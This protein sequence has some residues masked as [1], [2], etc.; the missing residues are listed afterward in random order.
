MAGGHVH[1]ST[2]IIIAAL[3]RVESRGKV[4]SANDALIH[5]VTK[6][7]PQRCQVRN[8]KEVVKHYCVSFIEFRNTLRTI[9][10]Y[11]VRHSTCSNKILQ[12]YAES[13]RFDR[14]ETIAISNQYMLLTYLKFYLVQR[15][16]SMSPLVSHLSKS[17][18][19]DMYVQM[20]LG[21]MQ[22]VNIVMMRLLIM[23][24]R[25]CE[26]GTFV[27]INRRNTMLP[28]LH[29][30]VHHIRVWSRRKCRKLH[31]YP[32]RN[33]R[34]LLLS[35]DSNT[36]HEEIRK[37][38]RKYLSNANKKALLHGLNLLSSAATDIVHRLVCTVQIAESLVVTPLCEPA[39]SR[40]S[41]IALYVCPMCREVKNTLAKYTS[42]KGVM[43]DYETSSILCSGKKCS[44]KDI[45]VVIHPIQ[46]SVSRTCIVGKCVTYFVCHNCGSLS[47]RL[48]FNSGDLCDA[49]S[50]ARE[51]KTTKTLVSSSD[52]RLNPLSS[53]V[54]NVKLSSERMID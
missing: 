3:F 20:T 39:K 8:L 23:D 36:H 13:D 18:D 30:A 9:I 15:V 48:L 21:D 37:V 31:S 12:F 28:P 10:W 25:V 38:V 46:V 35:S 11:G 24:R 4:R 5:I 26:A 7:L 27:K 6:A 41:N 44:E 17:C 19:W 47:K 29:N 33:F 16:H 22:D 43:F 32:Q 2:S 40:F 1:M 14:L 51:T 53:V 50:V 45:R 42:L 34:F 52:P 54:T 49:C